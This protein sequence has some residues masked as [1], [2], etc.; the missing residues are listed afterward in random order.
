ME[1]GDSYGIF[2]WLQE[3]KDCAIPPGKLVNKISEL[4]HGLNIQFKL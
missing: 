4:A 3:G 2:R 1:D